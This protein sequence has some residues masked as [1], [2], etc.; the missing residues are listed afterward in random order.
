MTG[1][2]RVFID[3]NIFLYAADSSSVFNS[4]AKNILEKAAV[5]EFEAV[6]TPQIIFELYSVLTNKKRLENFYSPSEAN[7]FIEATVSFIKAKYLFFDTT[8]FAIVK[9][10]LTSGKV[11]DRQVFD[12]AIVAVMLSNGVKKIY[13]AN[14]KDFI[15]LS[16]DIEVVN[17]FKPLAKGR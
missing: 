17:P 7:T 10:I 5:G 11:K 6:I 16:S 15:S 9:T 1:F 3:T 4:K 12:A 2:K 13:T 8:A 14:S